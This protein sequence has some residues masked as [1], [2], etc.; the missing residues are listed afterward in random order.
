MFRK[1]FL[2]SLVLFGLVSFS[3]EGE[4]FADAASDMEQAKSHEMSGEYAQAEAAYKM[5]ITDYPGTDYALQAQK[6]LAL[7][8]IIWGKK[9]E[10]EAAVNKLTADF[11][12]NP[13]LFEVLYR[14][15]ERYQMVDMRE[16]AKQLYQQVAG[17]QHPGNSHRVW[18][19]M[20]VAISD[21]ELGNYAEADA[22]INKLT[23]DFPG[24]PNLPEALF[25]T[26]K[27]CQ[28]HG[29]EEKAR[30]LYQY[31][32]TEFPGEEYGMWGQTSAIISDIE[33]RQDVNTVAAV[34]SLNANFSDVWALPSAVCGVAV[35]FQ[36]L[37]EYEKANR[38]YQYVIDRWPLNDHATWV[39]A[40]CAARAN[41]GLGNNSAA[42]AA[43]DKLVA[44]FGDSQEVQ[45]AVYEIGLRYSNDAIRSA[46]EGLDT[47]AKSNCNKAIVLYKIAINA[48]PKTQVAAWAYSMEA[49]CHNALGEYQKAIDCYNEILGG[50]RDYYE[51]ARHAQCMI[52]QF[53]QQMGI[54]GAMPKSEADEATKQAYEQMLKRYPNCTAAVVARS[55]LERYTRRTGAK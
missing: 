53:Y 55:W 20:S 15:A 45:R 10:A 38:L 8:Y 35:A 47:E 28:E 17:E 16:Q 24:D 14:I 22:A 31:I 7:L 32:A 44:D 49:D 27:N 1:S 51:Y 19:Q 36:N 4:C 6:Q 25:F 41:I 50:W 48:F 33:A 54:S 37:G 40:Q 39:Q 26:G 9:S 12:E 30:E 23:T 21:M 2:V 3:I 11:S 34:E 18:A 5:I 43:I 29:R 13:A 46:R 52:G 42:Q